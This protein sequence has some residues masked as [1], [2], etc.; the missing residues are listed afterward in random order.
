MKKYIGLFKIYNGECQYDN[1]QT[2]E[3]NDKKT[4]VEEW[5]KEFECD[6]MNEVWELVTFQEVENFEELWKFLR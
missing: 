2:Y 3:T 4:E 6:T 1:Y 5:F